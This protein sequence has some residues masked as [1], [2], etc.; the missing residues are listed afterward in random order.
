MDNSKL[1][2]ELEHSVREAEELLRRRKEALAA[3]KGKTGSPK[4]GGRRSG[5]RPGSIPA[6]VFSA[7]KEF[8]QPMSL[9]D[10]VGS[11]RKHNNSLNA[12]RVS[13]AI[14]RYVRMGKYFVLTEDGK[15]WLK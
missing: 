11:V 1:I 7:L 13:I 6:L 14:S 12:R 2:A 8:N 4:D 10:L 9:D 15:Y 5:F 3:L